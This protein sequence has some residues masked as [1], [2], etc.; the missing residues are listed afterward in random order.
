MS[1]VDDPRAAQIKLYWEPESNR[2]WTL[3]LA[4]DDEAIADIGPRNRVVTVDIAPGD[5]KFEIYGNG[6]ISNSLAL[7]V[8]EGD[9]IKLAA[10][11]RVYSGRRWYWDKSHPEFYIAPIG[12]LDKFVTAPTRI[13]GALWFLSRCIISAVSAAILGTCIV[14]YTPSSLPPIQRILTRRWASWHRWSPMI[15]RTFKDCENASLSCFENSST[16]VQ[17]D[18]TLRI[19]MFGL[20]RQ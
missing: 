18:R 3:T 2:R 19:R 10:G 20:H 14:F 4:I 7:T 15:L 16:I 12:Y 13:S 9:Q 6:Q 17:D 5:H 1:E 11:H 8:A